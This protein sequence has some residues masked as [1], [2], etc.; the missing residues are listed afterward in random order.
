MP[1]RS[2]G[3]VTVVTAG[4]PVRLTTNRTD[5]AQPYKAHS[6]FVEQVTGNTGKL[7]VGV[8]SS[9][10]KTTLVGVVAVI[11]APAGSL[12]FLDMSDELAPN[13]IAVSEMWLDAD[14]SGEGALVSVIEG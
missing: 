5:P 13:G 2:L 4:V 9:M 6:L 10:N 11:P 1:A 12:P 3:K 8:S 14:T 7:Y